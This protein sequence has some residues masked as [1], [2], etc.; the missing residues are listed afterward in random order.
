MIDIKNLKED[1]YYQ[2]GYEDEIIRLK[3]YEGAKQAAKDFTKAQALLVCKELGHKMMRGG[4]W[5][6][7]E[8]CLMYRED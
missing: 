4:S 1:G 8:R 5:C 6:V 2:V 7:C 3:K